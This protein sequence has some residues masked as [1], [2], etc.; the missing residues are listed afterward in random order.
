[1]MIL[2]SPISQKVK[3]LP[4]NGLF[5]TVEGPDGSGKTSLIGP[6]G[7]WIEQTAKQKCLIT[8][9]PGTPHST[10]CSDL[11][12]MIKHNHSVLEDTEIFLIIADRCQHVN[13]VIKPALEEGQI[14]LCDRYIDSTYAYQGWG[15]RHGDPESMEYLQYLN[16]KSTKGLVPDLTILLMVDPLVGAKRAS[17]DKNRK[18]SDKFD[19]IEKEFKKRVFDGYLDLYN[20]EKDNRNFLYLD[21]TDKTQKQ[22]FI[23]ITDYL[24]KFFD[25]MLFDNTNRRKKCLLESVV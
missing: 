6:L 9:E 5:V 10:I 12:E 8:R 23:E 20:K 18:E 11:R 14:V 4:Y 21:T 13:S 1:M 25:L 2:K 22:C 15:R 7:E 19:V 17:G 16:Q 24:I 3:K